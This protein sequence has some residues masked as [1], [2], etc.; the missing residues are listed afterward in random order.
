DG[1]KEDFDVDSTTVSVTGKYQ[2]WN[3]FVGPYYSF[4]MNKLTIDLRFVAGLVH[5]STPEFKV[6]LEDQM[7]ATFYQ[8][9]STSNA[10]GFQA[11]AGLRYQLAGGLCAKLNADY[12]YAH[13]DFMITNDN[14]VNSAGRLLTEYKEPVSM[15]NLNIGLAYQF[16]K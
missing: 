12:Y 4:P 1:Y 9:S 10:F 6:D 3:F 11:G 14:R 15:I 2:F 13:P 5:A 8:R 7:N 16:G